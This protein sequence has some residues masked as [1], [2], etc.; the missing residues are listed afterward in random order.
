MQENPII[1]ELRN[2]MNNDKLNVVVEQMAS[3]MQKATP[4]RVG[5][6]LFENFQRQIVRNVAWSAALIGQKK[7]ILWLQRLS[8]AVE[9]AE[10]EIED[11]K[12]FFESSI[13]SVFL[14]RDSS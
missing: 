11:A 4:Q 12:F 5:E 2:V 10:T 7:T 3:R 14:T 13:E 8:Q 1:T 6:V 9:A